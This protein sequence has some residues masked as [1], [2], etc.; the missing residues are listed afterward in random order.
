LIHGREG[1]SSCS[2]GYGAE[3]NVSISAIR[4]LSFELR[5]CA[6]AKTVA[7]VGREGC[8]VILARCRLFFRASTVHCQAGAPFTLGETEFITAKLYL[9]LQGIAASVPPAVAAASAVSE[10]EVAVG[11]ALTT[12]LATDTGQQIGP[13]GIVARSE[14]LGIIVVDES[15]VIII[16][17]VSTQRGAPIALDDV[18]PAGTTDCG[19]P[20]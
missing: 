4:A 20:T 8:T 1:A 18:T 5:K 6:T 14:T 13:F 16:H 12:G 3:K 9:G 7:S 2:I 17:A 11:D 15:V 10:V 19:C